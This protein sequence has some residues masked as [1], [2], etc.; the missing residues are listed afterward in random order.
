MDNNSS[1][2]SP[3]T[4]MLLMGAVILLF[5][6]LNRPSPQ[7]RQLE[8]EL[9]S[10]IEAQAPAVQAD[11]LDASQ[12]S[13]IVN[14]VRQ[15]GVAD[16]V[17]GSYTLALRN[18]SLT[19]SADGALTGSI[20]DGTVTAD[21]AQLTT[22]RHGSL[23]PAQAASAV[24]AL[25]NEVD[26]A[27]RYQGFARYLHGDSA[28]VRLANEYVT[29]EVAN[30]GG[31][32]SR[33]TLNDYK[34]YDS[35]AVTLMTPQLDSYSFTLTTA[36]Q[37]FETSEFFF[38]PTEVTD[39]TVT[40]ML[41]LG[42]GAKWGLR[43]TLLPESYC[44][45][46]DV[47]QQ[48]IGT[49][50]PANTAEMDFHWHSTMLRNEAGRMF[51]ER[52]SALYYKYAGGDVEYLSE[53]KSESD[54]ISERITWIGYKNQFFSTILVAQ[55]QFT[56]AD[57]SSEVIEND[58][59]KLK[60]MSTDAT[61]DYSLA[62]AEPARF[63]WFFGPN[64][65]PLLSDLEDEV[66]E[67]Q[68]LNFTKV[69][70]L[71]WS[72]FRW[73]NTLIVIPVFDFLGG[74]ISS[75]GIIILLLTIFIKI[76]LFPFT[77]KSYMSQAKMRV[78]TPEINAINEK[79]PGNE[80]AMKRQQETMALYSR[81]GASPF[82][83]CLPMLLQMPILIAMFNFFPSAIELRGQAFL[84]AKDLSAP[85]AIVSWTTN[86]PFISSTFGNHI[87]LFCLLMTVTNIIYTKVTMQ[88]QPG[89]NQMPMMKWMM[90]LMPLMF[91]VFFN[92]YAAGLSY[93][94]FLSL[95]ITIIQTY[96]FRR[97][98][99]EDKVRA[100]MRENAKKPRKKSGFMARLEEAQRRQQQMLREQ[101]KQRGKRR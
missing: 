3:V 48:N 34:R 24:K 78:L 86:I 2:G 45:K 49:I 94:Y 93:Y 4:A 8:D 10:R 42:N 19:V 43:Y 84:W 40:M 9:N 66:I 17:S 69:I 60:A 26:N 57:L 99:N 58:P 36:N 20:T 37:R 27:G 67:G 101:E 79:W 52:N 61:F 82:S 25:M 65:Y 50:L 77:Y 51:E 18:G 14:T 22:G 87:S 30:K 90:Y 44:V 5:M 35:T 28:T 53:S 83:G 46:M 81:A 38:Q 1:S 56:T 68:D 72:L 75:Y 92:N 91:L 97:V 59:F 73:I 76:I 21:V 63:V 16:S 71:G 33:A 11:S 95:L 89:G 85:D 7:D 32:I 96:I 62:S 55:D 64:S 70:P 31:M 13:T 12:I 88:S 47:V 98:V 54:N 29:I 6:W 15:T 23:T 80:N 74:F 41:D 100:Q 39:T